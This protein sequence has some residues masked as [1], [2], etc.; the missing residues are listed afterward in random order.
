MNLSDCTTKFKRVIKLPQRK[1]RRLIAID[2]TKLKLEH[3]QIFVWSARDVGTGEILFVWASD[4]RSSFHAYF[5]LKEVPRFCKN[6]PEVVVDKGL[7]YIQALNRLG[8]WYKHE[9]FG[10]RNSIESLFSQFKYRTKIFNSR[11]PYRSFRV[12]SELVG[13][14]YGFL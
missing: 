9:T 10:R 4:G 1:E 5:F 13:E 3:K 6:K 12:C 2:E 7:W 11:F 14:L 8:L